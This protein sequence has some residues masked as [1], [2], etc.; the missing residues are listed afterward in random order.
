MNSDHLSCCCNNCRASSS[1]EVYCL[2]CINSIKWWLLWW[3]ITCVY[4]TPSIHLHTALF[5]LLFPPSLSISTLRLYYRDSCI[6][7]HTHTHTRMHVHTHMH[8]HTCIIFRLWDKTHVISESDLFWLSLWPPFPFFCKW[9]NFVL[10][11][12][13]L[14]LQ[15]GHQRT[16]WKP[17]K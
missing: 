6:H 7:S 13:R 1:P 4:T 16:M 11:Y 3:H 15:P 8:A 14:K 17:T 2:V 9:H 10:H 12:C 5:S